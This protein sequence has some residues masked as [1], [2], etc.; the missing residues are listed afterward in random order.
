MKHPEPVNKERIVSPVDVIVSKSDEKGDITYA[1][2]IFIKISGYKHSELMRRPH[3]I[4]RHPDMPKIIFKYLWDNLEAGKEVY[5]FVKNL[6]KDGHYYWVLA[7][8]R[9]A[10]N[11][12]GT[13][14]NYVSTRKSATPQA[15]ALMTD[16][17]AQLLE[18]E[19]DQ[20]IEA[21]QEAL[22]KFLTEH[23][24]TPETFNEAM[25]NLNAE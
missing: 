22:M 25:Q 9:P 5:A 8:V 16:L 13:F 3:S 15:K 17:Y 23:G 21:S 18:V 12:D 24:I 20:G 7:Y 14:R 10:Y 1:N 11:K 4:L 6:C 2:P 19:K